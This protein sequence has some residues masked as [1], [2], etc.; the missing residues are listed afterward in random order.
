MFIQMTKSDSVEMVLE[1]SSMER[2]VLYVVAVAVP[3][4][5]GLMMWQ[6]ATTMKPG[7]IAWEVFSPANVIWWIV[8]A[9]DALVLYFAG[10]HRLQI[11]FRRGSYKAITGP[12]FAPKSYS[13]QTKDFYGLCVRSEYY[14]RVKHY[15]VDLDWNVPGRAAFELGRFTNLHKAQERQ[16]ELAARMG[17]LPTGMEA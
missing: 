7:K 10:P 11:N 3:L 14:R 5:F 13:G 17:N 16:S 2:L 1:R 12:L 15:R 9:L 8:F 4:F 6:I